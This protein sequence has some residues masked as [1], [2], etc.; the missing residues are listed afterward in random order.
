M[1]TCTNALKALVEAKHNAINLADPEAA[2][3]NAM[4]GLLTTLATQL[5]ALAATV[6]TIQEWATQFKVAPA[7]DAALVAEVK[8]DESM[9]SKIATAIENA[10]H[11]NPEAVETP[12][13]TAPQTPQA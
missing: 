13:E 10:L 11:I 9:V 1:G 12:P 3:N 5:D 8:H 2:E 4:A 6:E 7:A